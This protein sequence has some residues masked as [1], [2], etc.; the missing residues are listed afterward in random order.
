MTLRLT[1]VHNLLIDMDGVLYRGQTPLTGAADLIRFLQ[2]RDLGY[3]LVTNN[4]TLSQDQF[5]ERLAGMGM[6]VAPE[7]ILTSGVATAE[8]LRTLAPNGAGVFV[9]GEAPLIAELEKRGFR[10]A[11]RDAEYVVCGWDKGINFDKLRTATLAIRDGATFIGTNPD[12]TYPLENDLIPGAGALLAAISA[13]TDVDPIV[14][15]KPETIM[16]EQA[17]RML[18]ASAA[19]TALLGDRLDTDILGGKRA[20]VATIM[21]LTGISTPAEVEASELKPDIL[22][23]DLPALLSAWRQALDG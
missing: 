12:R 7:H 3:L 4:S 1:D 9:V 6:D 23:P 13:A 2:Q 5:A 8:Y 11:G 10:L 21:V 16:F 18:R 19:D 20:G 22:F 15:G 17:L 14:V